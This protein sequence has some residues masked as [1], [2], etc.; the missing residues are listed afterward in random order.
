MWPKSK[1]AR[2]GRASAPIGARELTG[3]ELERTEGGVK[4]VLCTHEL[5]TLGGRAIP[6][7]WDIAPPHTPF[8]SHQPTA[9][10]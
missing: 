9:G 8:P 7:P 3:A 4:D 10:I 5:G 2:T 1:I 6:V